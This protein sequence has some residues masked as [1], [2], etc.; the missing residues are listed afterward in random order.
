MLASSAGTGPLLLNR[1]L[2]E[3]PEVTVFETDLFLA[4][5]R[6]DAVY[7]FHYTGRS[8]K[9]AAMLREDLARAER[10]LAQAEDRL[11]GLQRRYDLAQRELEALRGPEFRTLH[12]AILRLKQLF[13]RRSAGKTP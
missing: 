1:L 3:F 11:A 10:T 5:R 4:T 13:L 2:P 9:D 7:A 6:E 8:W 12:A